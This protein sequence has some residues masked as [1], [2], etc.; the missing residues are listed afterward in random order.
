MRF[1]IVTPVYNAEKYLPD[2]IR[3]VRSQSLYD[4]ELIMVDDGSADNSR[5]IIRA[6]A[7]EDPRIRLLCLEEN[8]GSCFYPRRVA[9]EQSSGDYIVN[10]D[11]D[12]TVEKDYLYQ[13][14]STILRTGADLVYADMFLVEDGEEPI[15]F[16]PKED[17][18]YSKLYEGRT[19]FSMTLDGWGV[20]G[21]AATSRNLAL[22]SLKL[23]D[24]EFSLDRYWGAFH[25]ENLTR[26]D[27]FLA[28]KVAFAPTKYF[29]RQIPESLSHSVSLGKFDLL[30]ADENLCFFT[31]KFFGD[32][33]QE[34]MLAERQFFHHII[35]S[36]RLLN[37]N[38]AFEG[39]DRAIEIIK[40]AIKK[41]DHKAI[42]DIVSPRYRTLIKMGYHPSKA[43]LK[44]FDGKKQS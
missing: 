31:F 36:L 29:Y 35:E 16:I 18:V 26:L 2:M 24:Q 15:K 7:L 44:M 10:I 28:E 4:W 20:S 8:S 39:R 41:V 17:S 13:M 27:L 22:N 11:A 19:I 40:R 5:E 9:I 37:T 6:A 23:Y 3:S 42:R 12:D 43:I 38:P 33:S 21:V 1:S 30:K 25:D 32:G 34:Y 14:E